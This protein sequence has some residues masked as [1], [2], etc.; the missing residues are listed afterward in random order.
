[1]D[2]WHGSF[3]E[4]NPMSRL[5]EFGFEKSVYERPNQT[6][7]CGHARNGKCCLAG[8]DA[9]GHCTATTECRPLRKGDHWHCTRPAFLGGPCA[10]GPLPDGGCCRVIPKC[11]PIRSLRSWRGLTVALTVA[12][13]LAAL[14]LTFGTTHGNR[15][16]SPGELSFSHSSVSKSDCT[17]CHGPLEGRPAGWLTASKGTVAAHDNSQLCLKCHPYGEASLQPH[18]LPAAR[19]RSLTEEILKR[20]GPGSPPLGLKLASFIASPGASSQS[21]MACAT[22]HKEHRGNEADLKKLTNRQCQSC[23]VTQFASLQRDHP[24]FTDYPFP[25]PTRIL[26]NHQSHFDAHFKDPAFAQFARS[27]QDCHQTDL[28]GSTMTVKG[29]ETVCVSCHDAQIKGKSAVK[30][31]IPFI[32][33]PQMDDRA[34][35]GEYAIG[36]WPA[37]ADAQQ[38]NP[39]LRLLLAADPPL[40]QAL[41]QLEGTDLSNLPKT[42]AAKLKAAQM[43]AWGIKSLLFD[44]ETHGQEELIRRI[45]LS[46]GRTHTDH[47]K[48]GLVAFINSDTVRNTFT[49]AFP[50][51]QNEVLDYR[52][53]AKC[54]PTVMVPSPELAKPGP[55]K[56]A[57]PD[58]WVG[59][60][61]WYSPDGLLTLF[62]HPRGHADRFLSSWMSLAVDADRNADPASS[63]AVF[64]ELSA[65]AAAGLCIKCHSIDDKPVKQVNW[66]AFHPDPIEHDFNHFSH[67]AHLSLL[68]TSGCQSCHPMNRTESPG[69]PAMAS[70]AETGPHDASNF[71]SNFQTIDKG[72]CIKCHRPNQVRDDCL[73]CHNYHIGRFEPIVASA[74]VAPQS[75]PGGKM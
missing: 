38:I 3:H 63:R 62:Y 12:A 55:V 32:I 57:A 11:S 68:D 64:K 34:L 47:E 54:A 74:K 16:I 33:L 35:N 22:C 65:P 13:T 44:L 26:F 25:R 27:C 30:P 42:N 36:N 48:E 58:A 67:S 46:S 20:D 45:S 17:Q 1:M 15:V 71:H 72:K 43:V 28:R 66:M 10:E 60:G 52:D 69:K 9:H 4:A 24:P 56:T 6:W 37:D 7:I 39:F 53:H 73:L 29:F 23:H 61:G 31:G 2:F 50:N 49:N 70:T 19:L 18:S 75:P 59:Q 41:N 14:F 21:N 5:Q 51:L 40:R 8:P